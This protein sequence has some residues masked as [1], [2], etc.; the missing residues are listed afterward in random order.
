MG[1]LWEARLERQMEH[2]PDGSAP[3]NRAKAY[4]C[5]VDQVGNGW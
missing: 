2:R 5:C 4:F 1:V 3:V